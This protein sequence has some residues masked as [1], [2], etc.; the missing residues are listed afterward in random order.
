M[1]VPGLWDEV[2]Q[3]VKVTSWSQLVEPAFARPGIRGLR[4]GVDVALWLFHARTTVSQT[5][6]ETGL[7]ISLGPNADLRTLYFRTLS[8]L[9]NGVL[10]CF[11]FDGPKKPKWKRDKMVQGAYSKT[12]Q[13]DLQAM[14]DALGMEWR[15]APGEA[16]A[17]LAA[18][19]ERGEI[20]AVLTDDVD[21]L[22]F[23]D[24]SLV[25]IRNP[26]KNLSANQ[27]KKAEERRAASQSSSQSQS[28]PLPTPHSSTETEYLP[29]PA[30][31]EHALVVYKNKDIIS[32]TGLGREEL[33]L[34]ALMSG[35]DYDTKGSKRIG[36]TIAIALAKA[37]YAKSLFEGIR[38]V[39]ESEAATAYPTSS[40]GVLQ[41]FFAGW[42]AEV[43][44]E[45]RTNENQ[46]FSKRQMKLAD[47]FE[48]STFFPDMSILGLYLKPTVSDPHEPGYVV[49]TWSR[50][51]DVSRIAHF[52]SQMFQWS[53][54]ELHARFRSLLWR[55]LAMRQI[56]QSCLSDDDE[57]DL[58][59]S[60]RLLPSDYLKLVT[61]CKSQAS[62]DFV[63]AW[64]VELD[65]NVF[66][67]FVDA[68]LPNSDPYAFPDIAAMSE[69]ELEEFTA[70]RKK[71]GKPIKPPAP[72]LGK[73]AYRHWIPCGILES[74]QEGY[75]VVKAYKK[76]EE[77]KK[78][79]K[80][81]EEKRKKERQLAR[82]SPDKK[83]STSRSPKKQPRQQQFPD[84]PASVGASS[85]LDDYWSQVQSDRAQKVRQEMLAQARK[86]KGKGKGKGKA[87]AKSPSAGLDSSPLQSGSS[88]FGLRDSSNSSHLRTS[89]GT[90]T[91]LS[92]M[93]FGTSTKIRSISPRDKDGNASLPTPP[94]SNPFSSSATTRPSAGRTHVQLSSDDSDASGTGHVAKA[95]RTS[96]ASTS[97][98]KARRKG[99]T[100]ALEI[101]SSEEVSD[102]SFEG[103][104][105]DFLAARRRK[106]QDQLE[107]KKPDLQ[108]R[109]PR[110]P[111]ATTPRLPGGATEVLVLSD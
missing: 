5:D 17:E 73:T 57:L 25:V 92:G 62:T 4:V 96:F 21:T 99:A 42:R 56:R 74:C 22:L 102:G 95:N 31:H 75:E 20:D 43:A 83:K 63:S 107:G 68:G 85:E 27:S 53:N 80:A 97:P 65:P 89:K 30:G 81:E 66:D 1:G 88:I 38:R 90:A 77:Q 14:F 37:G 109:P 93:G 111:K 64:R 72:P 16:E 67:P 60:A 61:E 70:R 49:P 106:Q 19:Q 87:A 36:L 46:L 41:Q 2:E 11:V 48:A 40:Q 15:I 3:G 82:S 12:P 110:K 39:Q 105:Q 58:H 71:E 98:S 9:G 100:P 101:S 94:R 84:S 33:I 35:A 69:A 45:L 6:S 28:P 7:P 44:N 52:S 26:G 86:D 108:R 50:Q 10:A 51:I 8:F 29:V 34:A 91:T 18:M 23:G 13:R 59:L 104:L 24:P 54:V 76:A 78:K 55:G 32:R 79:E 47:E 103:D